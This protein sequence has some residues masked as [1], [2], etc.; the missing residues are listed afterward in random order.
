MNFSQKHVAIS[1]FVLGQ[2]DLTDQ[3]KYFKH[4]IKSKKCIN[5]RCCSIYPH[6]TVIKTTQNN[7]IMYFL[8]LNKEK[9]NRTLPNKSWYFLITY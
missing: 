7:L 8:K 3:R 2:E 1:P 6:I 9:D 4:I 5:T